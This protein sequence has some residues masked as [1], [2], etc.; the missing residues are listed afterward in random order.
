MPA[1]SPRHGPRRHQQEPEG[2]APGPEKQPH[3]RTSRGDLDAA[4]LEP[5]A[6]ATLAT[7]ELCK[8]SQCKCRRCSGNPTS[9]VNCTVVEGCEARLLTFEDK[10][11]LL[12]TARKSRSEITARHLTRALQA[13]LVVN[14]QIRE[15]TVDYGLFSVQDR[16][17]CEGAY[18]SAL[19]WSRNVW[20]KA[21]WDQ[22]SQFLTLVA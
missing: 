17:L 14:A 1:Q 5:G 6:I 16:R 7:Q 21:R 8:C 22:N 4:L 15:G 11:S 18:H 3:H 13:Q 10:V 9:R 19:G 2:G 20:Q 12:T